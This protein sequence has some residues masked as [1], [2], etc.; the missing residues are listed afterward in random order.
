MGACSS[1]NSLMV[2]PTVSKKPSWGR[3]DVV[4]TQHDLDTR[5]K[6]E[7]NLALELSQ[8]AGA[9]EMSW[10][11]LES[12]HR[13]MDEKMIA[14]ALALSYECPVLDDETVSEAPTQNDEFPS[15]VPNEKRTMSVW[16]MQVEEQRRVT[17]DT[18]PMALR[19]QLSSKQ[20]KTQFLP[21]SWF[22]SVT[23]LLQQR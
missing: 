7:I 12:K 10:A 1:T 4:Y 23:S 8:H 19:L 21:F 15:P 13:A 14:E 18:G 22:L 9:D 16:Q 11:I 20:T 6:Q 17:D 3:K 2:V 5:C